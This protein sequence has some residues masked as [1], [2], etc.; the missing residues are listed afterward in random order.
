MSMKLGKGFLT[1]DRGDSSLYHWALGFK[2][3]IIKPSGVMWQGNFNVTYNGKT[4]CWHTFNEGDDKELRAFKKKLLLAKSSIIEAV[5]TWKMLNGERPKKTICKRNWLNGSSDGDGAFSGYINYFVSSNPANSFDFVITMASCDR[6]IKET[7]EF[8]SLN[9]KTPG[10][11]AKVILRLTAISN[12]LQDAVE[13][14][15]DVV[16]QYH[17]SKSKSK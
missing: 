15:D 12:A 1:T 8:P 4:I 16:D 14:I 9:V 13:A 3:N 7:M 2:D 11:N 10:K 6:I 5:D 17:K